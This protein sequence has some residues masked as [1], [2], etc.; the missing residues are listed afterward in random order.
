VC[1][2]REPT[3]PDAAAGA[4]TAAE[5]IYADLV[6]AQ[7]VVDAIDSGLFA[8][9]RGKD[10][11][12]WDA[13]FKALHERLGASLA[14]I[15][16]TGLTKADAR[17]LAVLRRKLDTVQP[18]EKDPR[19]LRCTDAQRKELPRAALSAALTSCFTEIA[20]NLEFEG[21]RLDR[22]AALGRLHTIV[23][24]ERRKMLFLSF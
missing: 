13:K 1:I 6:D 23:E 24:P 10:Q 17:V 14:S 9:Y 20:D 19:D 11:H 7:G 18:S 22:V 2:S 4:L 15:S 3:T 5:S 8:Q 21:E 16:E 12:E